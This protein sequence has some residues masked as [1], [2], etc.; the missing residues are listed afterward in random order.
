MNKKLFC[1]ALAVVIAGTIFVSAYLASA[2]PQ[3]KGNKRV[4]E[5]RTFIHFRKGY[6]KPPWAGGP[7]DEEKGPKCYEFLGKGVKWKNLL[8]VSYVVHK[9]LNVGAVHSS[10]ETWDNV[11]AV[12]LFGSYSVDNDADWDGYEGDQPDGKNELVFENY[13]QEGVIAVTVIWGY[14]SGPPS[15]REIIEFDILFNKFYE[16]GDAGTTDEDELGDTG[17]MDIQ[18]IATHEL[19]HGLGLGDIYNCPEVTMY[20]YSEEGETK[21]RTLEAPDITGIQELYGAP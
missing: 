16:W 5:K 13:P 12:D 8:P 2:A 9:K 14:F 20:G 1:L 7:K 10:V 17:V 19:G 21:K 6:G 18:N 11:T 3:G 4:L 15:T